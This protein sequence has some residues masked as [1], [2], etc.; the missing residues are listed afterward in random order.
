MGDTILTDF[1]FDADTD[2]LSSI[3]FEDFLDFE[4]CTDLDTFQEVDN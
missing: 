3:D 4:L 1:S 2:D